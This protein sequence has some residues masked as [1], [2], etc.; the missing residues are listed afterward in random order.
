MAGHFVTADGH[1]CHCSPLFGGKEKDRATWD[2]SNIVAQL[3]EKYPFTDRKSAYSHYKFVFAGDKAYPNIE[4]PPGWTV[5]ATTSAFDKTSL[6]HKEIEKT[7]DYI[8]CKRLAVPKAKENIPNDGT[9]VDL[10]FTAKLVTH[11]A[12]VERVFGALKSW[13]LLSSK[14]FTTTHMKLLES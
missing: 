9:E 4:M 7:D 1:I 6:M 10:Y 8:H 5:L 14:S 11:R 12:V 3:E 13:K 2:D